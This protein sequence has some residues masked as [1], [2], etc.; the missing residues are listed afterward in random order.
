MCFSIDRE[1]E[2]AGFNIKYTL[3]TTTHQ[4]TN[5]LTH[6]HINKQTNKQTRT[7]EQVKKITTEKCHLKMASETLTKLDSFS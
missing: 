7:S 4:H 6:Q 2:R 5:T 3:N 1:R